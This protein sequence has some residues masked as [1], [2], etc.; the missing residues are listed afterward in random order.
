MCHLRPYRGEQKCS[1][2]H[3]RRG[4]YGKGKCRQVKTE[5]A[6][7]GSCDTITVHKPRDIVSAIRHALEG[8]I[9][10]SPACPDCIGKNTPVLDHVAFISPIGH[11][12]DR[13]DAVQT[14]KGGLGRLWGFMRRSQERKSTGSAN[15]AYSVVRTPRPGRYRRGAKASGNDME[16]GAG[17]SGAGLGQP[18][19]EKD[20]CCGGWIGR[21]SDGDDEGEG[22]GADLIRDIYSSSEG[23][24]SV[25]HLLAAVSDVAE[26]H[27]SGQQ[28]PAW[29]DDEA[30]GE[31]PSA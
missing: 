30:P 8:K 13:H 19:D 16:K 4:L 24:E 28:D 31:E 14:P 1:L 9:M 21:D 17:G 3:R 11:G 7:Y 18:D 12:K 6:E 26:D 20:E 23:S 25:Q 10:E 15:Q 22:S 27:G 29:S 5:Q 2:C